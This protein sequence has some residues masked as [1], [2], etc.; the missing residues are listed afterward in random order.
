MNP[1]IIR[2]LGLI[3]LRA[4]AE[5]DPPEYRRSADMSKRQLDARI[6]SL[7][8]EVDNPECVQLY[9]SLN[10]IID[11][12]ESPLELSFLLRQIYVASFGRAQY[13]SLQRS[14]IEKSSEY[15][16]ISRREYSQEIPHRRGI[17]EGDE[18]IRLST[19]LLLRDLR[20]YSYSFQRRLGEA[21]VDSVL[22]PE[23]RGMPHIL[24][25]AA[26]SG[27]EFEVK[28]ESLRKAMAVIRGRVVGV[29]VTEATPAE[30]DSESLGENIYLLRF[31]VRK[32]QFAGNDLRRFHYSL[33]ESYEFQQPGFE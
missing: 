5:Y 15:R 22:E 30:Q 27:R 9:E 20:D 23:L 14:R 32:N 11:F 4:L 8:S 19:M 10:H 13:Y 6:R 29:I 21:E 33:R 7:L 18:L 28:V 26:A 25:Q 2:L 3:S 16:E 31:D 1:E 24:V 12:S 17:S